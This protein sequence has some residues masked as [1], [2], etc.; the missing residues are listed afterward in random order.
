MTAPNKK[1]SAPIDINAQLRADIRKRDWSRVHLEAD[2]RPHVPLWPRRWGYT[3][4]VL[5]RTRSVA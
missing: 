5:R 2:C 3:D 1:P 4:P